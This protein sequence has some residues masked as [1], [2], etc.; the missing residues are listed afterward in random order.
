MI[1]QTASTASLLTPPPLA[2]CQRVC[3][4]SKAGRER[5]ISGNKNLTTLQQAEAATGRREGV[6]GGEKVRE[7]GEGPVAGGGSSCP[8]P[9]S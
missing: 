6:G 1:P 7:S 3:R 5:P 2:N 4:W 9:W 8:F